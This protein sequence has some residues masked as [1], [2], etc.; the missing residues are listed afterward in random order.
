MRF[1][2]K[3]GLT[4]NICRTLLVHNNDLWVGTDKGLNR[5]RLDRAG[6]PITHYTSQDGLGS[7]IINSIY[8]DGTVLF[9][10]TPSGLS[11]FDETKVDLSEGVKLYLLSI[12][13][14]GKE[15]IQD[16]NALILPYKDKSIRLEFAAISY[17]S[18]GGISY[19][20]QIQGLDN[21]WRTTRETFVEYPALPSGDYEF[22]LQA[23]NKFGVT[24]SMTTLHFSIATPFWETAWF[25]GLCAL[26]FLAATWLLVS[27]RIRSI[28]RRQQE[29][30]RLSRRLVEM[31]HMA[32]QAQMNPHFIFNCLN[33]IQQYIFDQDIFAA[34][35]YLTGFSKL[36]R[37]T[38]QNSSRSFISIAGEVSYLSAYLSL[39]KLRFKEKMDY[40]IDVDSAINQHTVVIPPMLIQPYV[41]NSMRHGLRHKTSGKGYIRIKFEQSSSSLTVIVEDNGI[42]RKKAA[43]YK[44]GEHIEYQSRGMSLTA[45]RISMMNAIHGEGIGVNVIDLKDDMDQPIGTRVIVRFPLFVSTLKND[46]HD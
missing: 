1:D 33:S 3:Q 16:T 38:L 40:S 11:F 20:Y 13:N 45:E 27:L 29:E 2:I 12:L 24:S 32:L 37:E 42:G 5:I 28:R 8:A 26:L 23:T 31:E 15:H 21:T 36:I 19:R 25:Y 4:S 43:G 44:T 10:G 14:S 41:E 30:K 17:R 9:V 7:D 39:E 46:N 34:N 6:Y 18:V 22:R 35:K